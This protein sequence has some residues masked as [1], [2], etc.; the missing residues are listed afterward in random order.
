MKE[1]GAK[2]TAMLEAPLHE[3]MAKTSAEAQTKV[4]ADAEVCYS[5]DCDQVAIG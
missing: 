5:L 1:A 3:T 4:G 2:A